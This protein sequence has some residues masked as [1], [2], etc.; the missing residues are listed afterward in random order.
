MT[1]LPSVGLTST[2]REPQTILLLANFLDYLGVALV[3]PN[4]VF[5]WQ[6][7][8]ITSAGL[9]F[10]SSIYSISQ[11]VGGLILARLGDGIL[12]QKRTLLLSFVGTAISYGLVGVATRVET[13]VLARILVGLVKQTNTCSTALITKWTSKEA[14][15]GAMGRLASASTLSMVTGQALG[16]RLSSQYG[17]RAPC[18]LA[19]GIFAV[20]FV[21]VLFGLPKDA[22]RLAPATKSKG[23]AGSAPVSNPKSTQ[24]QGSAGSGLGTSWR[25]RLMDRVASMGSTFASAY[26][27][28]VARRVLLFRVSYGFLMRSAY[29]LHFLYEKD[30]WTL[31]PA[32]AGYLSS[33][34]QLLGLGVNS[35]LVGFLSQRISESNLVAVVLMTSAGNAALEASHTEFAI[36]AAVNLPLSACAGTI[37]RTTLSSTFSKAIPA[38]DAASALSVLD[39]LNSAVGVLAPIYGGVVLG[40]LGVGMQPVI[41]V[42]HYLIL[43]GLAQMTLTGLAKSEKAKGKDKQA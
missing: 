41:S 33:Y 15:M 39:L 43:L 7:V 31:T 3:L 21:L 38:E 20:A 34:K 37:M 32:T 19:V 30:R 42:T 6:D 28:P 25:A 40:R 24:V 11:L 2:M 22:P 13:L 26:R 18:F 12:G 9:G 14:R 8:G 35:L 27:S 10:V 1:P 4:L 5:F 16:G 23:K 36:Y 29:S 17:R